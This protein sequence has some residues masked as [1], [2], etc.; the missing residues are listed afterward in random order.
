[1]HRQ[2]Q[3]KLKSRGVSC[4]SPDYSVSRLVS[5]ASTQAIGPALDGSITTPLDAPMRG[6]ALPPPPGADAPKGHRCCFDASCTGMRAMGGGM[7]IGI[8]PGAMGPGT[9]GA[10]ISAGAGII[11]G[12]PVTGRAGAGG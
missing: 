9:R 5:A 2:G 4:K 10:G 3:H 7:G 1:M 6:A 8:I 11:G 12:A